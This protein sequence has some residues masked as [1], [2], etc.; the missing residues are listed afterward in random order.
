MRIVIDARNINSSTGRYAERLIHYLEE[1]DT[2]NHYIILVLEKDLNYYTPS[3][4]NFEVRGVKYPWFSLNEQFGFCRYLYKLQ[5][6][7]VHFTMPHHPI[8]YFGK[9]ITTFHDLTLLHTY[10]SDKN[11]LI[12]KTKQFIGR[13]VYLAMAHGATH[14]IAPTKFVQKE[15]QAF[16]HVPLSKISQIY[17]GGEVA[18]PVPKEYKPLVG[19]KFIMYVGQQSDY[20]NIRRLMQA[21]Q[22][23]RRTHPDL[24]LVLVGRLTG[25]NGKPLQTNKAWAEAQG[26][27]GVVYTDFLPDDNLAWAFQ[28]T[29]AYVFPSLLE[30]FGLP[31][32]EAM[33]AGAPVVSSNATCLPEVYG[34]AAIYFNPL[35]TA[36]MAA[37]I[38]LVLTDG[39][40][41]KS[42]QAKG[43]KVN[44]LY[45]WQ[46]M[47]SQTYKIYK[48]VLEQK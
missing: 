39:R 42:L 33:G 12:Y 18:N 19:K 41:R 2:T 37:K 36:E 26:F 44:A 24:L 40:L 4:P 30:G 10:N 47:A 25:K 46:K 16:S 27:E 32:L 31:A 38:E 8:L 7:V 13:F 11:F 20:K 23:L 45:S 1:L 48:T 14:L 22:I 28:H 29:Q 15:L 9:Y 5:A 35:D 17:E 34:D 6:D 43:Y 3:N 21:H